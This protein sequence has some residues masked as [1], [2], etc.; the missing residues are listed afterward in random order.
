[1]FRNAG[2][3]ALLGDA[4]EVVGRG[5]SWQRVG[6]CGVQMKNQHGLP[7]LGVGRDMAK[8]WQLPQRV[9]TANAL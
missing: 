3:F 9:G 8:V 6:S 1:M 2:S 5:R 7:D 4:G